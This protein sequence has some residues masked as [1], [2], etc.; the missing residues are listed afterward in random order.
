[1]K[2]FGFCSIYL[3]S[4]IF[5]FASCK[6]NLQPHKVENFDT[7]INYVPYYLEVYR[8]DSFYL[9]GFYQQSYKILDD[10]FKEYAPLNQFGLFEMQTYIKS[11]YQTK[12]YDMIKP[13]FIKLMNTW[14]FVPKTAFSDSILSNAWDRVKIDEEKIVSSENSYK[15]KIN[16]TL[17]ETIVAIKLQDQN[18][19][20]RNGEDSIDR[21]HIILLKDIFNKYGYPDFRLIGNSR[22]DEN[23]DLL[24][25]FNHISDNLEED[26]YIFFRESLLKYVRKGTASPVCLAFLEDKR[27][28]DIGE[29]TVYGT[30]GTDISFGEKRL[31]VDTLEVNKKRKSIGLPSLQYSKFKRDRIE[32][33]FN[34]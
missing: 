10:L 1:M 8:A 34:Q 19:R 3:I 15:E 33:L 25:V 21:Q 18:F 20:G 4:M 27:C 2:H 14:G 5:F 7:E 30:F 31:K 32:S 16:W 28:F 23:I 29:P 17:R 11:A 13:T 12:N 6:D 22:S 26:E 24:V 9:K